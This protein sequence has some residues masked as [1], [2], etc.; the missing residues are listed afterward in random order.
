MQYLTSH[1]SNDSSSDA[2]MQ[3]KGVIEQLAR[4]V[5]NFSRKD[6]SQSPLLL[7]SSS[8]SPPGMHIMDLPPPQ[9]V[10]Y[11]YLKEQNQQLSLEVQKLLQQLE[12]KKDASVCYWFYFSFI[13]Y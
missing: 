8:R 10:D 2:E 9:N 1:K 7:P 6:P 4:R 13:K 5:S 11:I 12:L 3:L